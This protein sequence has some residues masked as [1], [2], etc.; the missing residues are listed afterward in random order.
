MPF[1]KILTQESNTCSSTFVKKS[2]VE[3]W[4]D[5]QVKLCYF[6]CVSTERF[7]NLPDEK[8]AAIL[9]S[10]MLEFSAAGFAKARLEDIAAAAGVTK[11]L[12]YYYFEDREDLLTSLYSEV[13]EA[14]AAIISPPPPKP[15]PN[16]F[17]DWIEGVYKVAI[18]TLAPEPA[19]M[20]F[21]ARVI[22]EVT[23]G[24]I[25]P[26]F[27]KH[28]KGTR[29]GVMKVISLG[30][31]CGAVRTDLPDSLL[32]ASV[33]SLMSSSDQWILSEAKANRLSSKTPATVL[34]LYKSAFSQTR[35]KKSA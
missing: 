26:G 17:W 22:T 20:A 27:E 29:S 11:G 15:T 30:Q 31:S 1:L 16:E 10:A 2:E 32:L 12:L 24:I 4:F 7:K 19:M 25:P 9:N 23:N 34:R 28:Y 35:A 13:E 8:R 33:M 3:D 18:D 14:L 21:L 5:P 6:Q